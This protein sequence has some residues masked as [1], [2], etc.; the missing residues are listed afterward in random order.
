MRS[1]AALTTALGLLATTAVAL[2]YASVSTKLRLPAG[3]RARQVSAD[4]DLS[5]ALDGL[6]IPFADTT[7]PLGAPDDSLFLS[8]IVVGRGVQ[9]VCQP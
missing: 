1:H 8:S 9:N 5:E 3:I 6:T 4:C 2:P 7:P